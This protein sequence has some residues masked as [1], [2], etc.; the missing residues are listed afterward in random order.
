M[1]R[2][3][4]ALFLLLAG[5]SPARAQNSP[6]E[7]VHIQFGAA[8]RV[9]GAT[10]DA[11][12][13]LFMPSDPVA[14]QI[15]IEIYNGNASKLLATVLAI[16]SSLP[17]PVDA[18]L[19]DYSDTKP[20]ALRAWFHPGNPRGYEFVYTRDEAAAIFAASATPV[21]STI[22]ET[23]DAS[24]LGLLPIAHADDVYRGGVDT[25]L[26]KTLGVASL[27]PQA[28]DRLM[29]AR[30]AILS[31]IDAVP[32]DVALRLRLLDGQLRDV[33]EAYRLRK[34]DFDHKL[35]LAKSSL[36]NMPS[37]P[38]QN[39]GTFQQ[40]PALAH[41]LERVRAQIEAFERLLR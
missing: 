39:A 18:T 14:G 8:F 10:L 16:E 22:S 20:A 32:R 4:L 34:P 35:A 40:T 41:V 2:L 31:H 12:T 9:P 36:G 23:A 33:H 24:M 11:G 3:L 37:A 15:V 6:V 13:Y 38:D 21:P 19:V 29:L 5:F 1:A 30:V 26:A 17:R 7:R 25:D 27:P 28:T